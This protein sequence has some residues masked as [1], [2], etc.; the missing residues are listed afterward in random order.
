MID[1]I[2]YIKEDQM[3]FPYDIEVLYKT[4]QTDGEWKQQ[5]T[6]FVPTSDINATS[7]IHLKDSN[8]I[9]Q[10][11]DVSKKYQSIEFYIVK[12]TTD[13]KFIW[14]QWFRKADDAWYLRT[15]SNSKYSDMTA[16]VKKILAMQ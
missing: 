10:L 7:D 16:N 12:I 13:N 5:V 14:A 3:S 8:L 2:T 1:F 4:D 15:L 9:S 11:E 6:K